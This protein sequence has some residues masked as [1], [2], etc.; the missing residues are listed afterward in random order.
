[1]SFNR[2]FNEQL[3]HSLFSICE[4][5]E[6][7]D[8][9]LTLYPSFEFNYLKVPCSES[10]FHEIKNILKPVSQVALINVLKDESILK[11]FYETSEHSVARSLIQNDFVPETVRFD[12]FQIY[13]KSISPSDFEEFPL[14][15]RKKLISDLKNW[16]VLNEEEKLTLT[17]FLRKFH[18]VGSLPVELTKLF[19]TESNRE[20]VLQFNAFLVKYFPEKSLTFEETDFILN[21]NF[22]NAADL[23]PLVKEI[24]PLLFCRLKSHVVLNLND[25]RIKNLS[26][27]TLDEIKSSL[28]NGEVFTQVLESDNVNLNLSDFQFMINFVGYDYHKVLK[29]LNSFSKSKIFTDE[30]LLTLLTFVKDAGSL[31]SQN[32]SEGV[33][34]SFQEILPHLSINWRNYFEA[35]RFRNTDL[36]S[37]YLLNNCKGTNLDNALKLLDTW[38][39][40]LKD[41]VIVANNI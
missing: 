19:E 9:I 16:D 38:D 27:E 5:T 26:R 25:S 3:V 15:F 24:T 22:I 41:L 12:L 10:K 33:A 6:E 37:R 7:L 32:L 2:T 18:A 28:K 39:G 1:M 8:E 30:G 14:G 20:G 35:Y 4:T 13:Y 23:L 17:K 34:F 36:V 31:F 21:K 11:T 29:V 40:T